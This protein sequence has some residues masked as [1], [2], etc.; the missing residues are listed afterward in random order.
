VVLPL[1][2]GSWMLTRTCRRVACDACMGTE[3]MATT[4]NTFEVF[5]CAAELA[6]GALVAACLHDVVPAKGGAAAA[7][8]R[9]VWVFCPDPLCMSSRPVGSSLPA[10]PWDLPLASGLRLSGPEAAMLAGFELGVM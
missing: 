6:P 8:G 7:A 9:R 1:E 2:R 4:N 10:W 5:H 3:A